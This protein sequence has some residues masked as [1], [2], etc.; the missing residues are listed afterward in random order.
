[1]V[2][3]L[4]Y[5]EVFPEGMSPSADVPISQISARFHD[6]YPSCIQSAIGSRADMKI[7]HGIYLLENSAI[8]YLAIKHARIGKELAWLCSRTGENVII[9]VIALL[10]LAQFC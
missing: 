6:K 10:K 9:L 3:I 5:D 2:L 8:T 7:K 4:N 1:M